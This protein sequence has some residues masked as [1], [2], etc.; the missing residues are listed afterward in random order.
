MYK[1]LDGRGGPVIASAGIAIVGGR[2]TSGAY[3]TIP[4]GAVILNG[5]YNVIRIR[6]IQISCA[7]RTGA[8]IASRPIFRYHFNHQ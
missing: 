1:P 4:I 6:I 3:S 8:V 7:I 2:I 5:T